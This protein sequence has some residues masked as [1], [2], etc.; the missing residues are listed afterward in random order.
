[1]GKGRVRRIAAFQWLAGCAGVALASAPL[2]AQVPPSDPTELDPSAPLEPMPHLGVEWPDMDQPDP[3][4]PPEVQADEPD[5]AADATDDA[6]E[7]VDDAT[8]TRRYRWSISGFE[9]IVEAADIR[10]AFDERSVL[11]GDRNKQAN[12]HTNT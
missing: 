6:A 7:Q 4:P 3:D 11:E 12:E 5:V 10:V 9:G 1:M 8:A 2:H